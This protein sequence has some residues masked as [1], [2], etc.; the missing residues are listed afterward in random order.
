M[1]FVPIRRLSSLLPVALAVTASAAAA[2]SESSADWLE[3]C[4]RQSRRDTDHA[5]DVREVTIPAR[6]RIRVDGG[7]NGGIIVRGWD[8]NEIKVVARI[9]AQARSE[10]D[11]GDLVERVRIETSSDIR[12]TGPST[13]GREGWWVSFEV[14][15]PRRTDL[16]LETNNGG[17]RI[18]DVEGAIRFAAVNGGVQLSGL[19][20]DV[21]GATENGGLRVALDGDR[22]RGAGIDVRTQNGGVTV[23]VPRAYNADL[24]TGT[25]NGRFDIEFPITV[26]G[27][28]DRTISARLGS[29][30][31]PVRVRTQNGGVSVRE[32]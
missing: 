26:S 12:A 4:E 14:Y 9:E 13:R 30:G 5:C 18:A 2:Q 17:I 22:W 24:E 23:E 21:R 32:R 15:V 31:P 6:G 28:V 20:G 10:A 8:R 25:V 29:G 27:R 11:A 7:P 16:D 1:S 3:R 19:A